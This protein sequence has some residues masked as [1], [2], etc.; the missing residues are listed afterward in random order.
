MKKYLV[1]HR[2]YENITDEDPDFLDNSAAKPT[3]GFVDMSVA[4]SV[5]TRT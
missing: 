5:Y 4:I 2:W 3:F 1:M